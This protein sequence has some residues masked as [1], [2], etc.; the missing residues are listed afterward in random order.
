MDKLEQIREMVARLAQLTAEELDQ[1]RGL[2]V[3]AGDALDADPTTAESVAVL[4]ELAEAADAVMAHQ[5]ALVKEAAANEESKAASRERLKLLNGKP[6]DEGTEE[7]EVPAIEA[8]GDEG[9]ESGKVAD[10]A[11]E[12]VAASGAPSGAI[13]KMA[14][15]SGTPKASP[16][17]EGDDPSRASLIASGA[18]GAFREGE[19]LTD[20]YALAEGMA[21]ILR[22][23]RKSG[24][25]TGDILVASAEWTY[26]PDRV[27]E[28]GPEAEI[29][30]KDSKLMDAITHPMAIVASGGIC[31]PVNVDWSLDTWAVADRPLRDALPAFQATRGGLTYR[32]PIDFAALAGAT[33]VWSEATDADP[34]ASVKPVIQISCPSNQ[35]VY[36]DAIPTRLGFGNMQSRF[37]PETV[38][39]NTDLAIV[40]AAH[41]AE[42]NLLTKIATLCTGPITTAAY[43]G[44][45]RD[46][47]ANIDRFMAMYRDV[48]RLADSQMVTLL[49]PRWVRDIMRA[50]RAMEIA[51]DGSSVDPLAIP[52]SYIQSLFDIRKVNPVWLLDGLASGAV[53][54]TY[55]NQYFTGPVATGAIPAFPDK[56]MLYAFIEGSIQFL[57]SGRLDLGV[58]RDST[59]DST[60]DYETFVETFEGIANRGFANSAMSLNV[61]LVASGAS[62]GTSTPTVWA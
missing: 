54:G 36:V 44:A 51:H 1:L 11:P 57:D 37:D 8:K 38:A 12:P 4:N 21:K 3:E 29:S 23:A 40:A 43:L 2:I 15:R 42:V 10:P 14:K 6:E 17:A 39:M 5:E 22:A 32:S 13:G 46:M 53:A 18:G 27:L 31:A 33:A 30:L 60:N 50:D 62:A 9:D 28:S 35:T 24:R 55:P 16:E 52:D 34:G 59:L 47:L 19:K 49:L 41:V 20:R 7:V 25:N 26:P 56:A 45:T 58:V 61:Q 48:H